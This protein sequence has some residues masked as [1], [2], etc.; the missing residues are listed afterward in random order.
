MFFA[1]LVLFVCKLLKINKFMVEAAG[2]VLVLSTE[3]T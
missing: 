1:F 3:N 2:V